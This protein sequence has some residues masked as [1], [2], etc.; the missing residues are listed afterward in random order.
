MI[1]DSPWGEHSIELVPFS[2]DGGRVN[3]SS[4]ALSFIL[5]PFSAILLLLGAGCASL[6]PAVEHRNHPSD[7]GI[8]YWNGN[9]M[10]GSPSILINLSEQRAYFYKGDLLAGVS[11]ISSGREGH[12]TVTGDFKI[13]EK[14]RDHE[15]S[16][17]GDYVDVHGDI[18]QKDVD[19]SKHPRPPGARYQGAKMPYFMR[20]VGGTGLHAGFLP[21]Y[22]DSHGCIRMPDFMA[23]E[24][25]HATSLGTPVS[26]QP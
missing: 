17:F 12:D 26:I 9:R 7:D 13:I 5:L 25:F 24:F 8:S 15:S 4:P 2:R 14:D 3:P 20:I 23:Q 10:T 16:L 18:I 1:M 11:R 22:P 21:G 19:T 6:E